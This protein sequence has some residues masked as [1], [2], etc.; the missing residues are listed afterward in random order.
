MATVEDDLGPRTEVDTEDPPPVVQL[1]TQG[2]SIVDLLR[3]DLADIASIEDVYIPVKGYERTGLQIRYRLPESGKELDSITRKVFRETKD[4]YLRNINSIMDTMI[5]LCI[6]LYVQ[7]EGTDERVELDPN[8][9]G[10]PVRIGV[11]L[12]E[13]LGMSDSTRSTARQVIRK[14]FDNNDQALFVHGEKLSRWV[15]DTKTDVENDFFGMGE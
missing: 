10:S 9:T 3:A 12:A 5:A 14:L 15:G 8:E 11:D 4:K 1:G 6:G 2:A 7:P 13:I